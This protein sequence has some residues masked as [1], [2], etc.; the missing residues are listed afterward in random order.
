MAFAHVSSMKTGDAPHPDRREAA[1]AAR[2]PA[3]QCTQTCSVVGTSALRADQLRE[4]Q[5][6]RTTQ[7]AGLPLVTVPNVEHPR[8]GRLVVPPCLRKIGE[9]RDR[10]TAE[11]AAFRQAPAPRWS[12]PKVR[13]PRARRGRYGR[14]A[15]GPRRSRHRRRQAGR[16]C[17]PRARSSRGRS[18]GSRRARDS[19]FQEDARRRS[20]VADAGRRPTR[21]PR[22][23]SSRASA[24]RPGAG[25]KD[26]TAGPLRFKGAM[27]R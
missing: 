7:V 1:A 22:I 24:S 9:G 19:R 13:C 23:A 4:R 18:S 15:G 5:V 21:A 26:G 12:V 14:S 10:V 20:R 2:K 16:D 17:S 11:P 25:S 3:P 27:W 8:S 6:T